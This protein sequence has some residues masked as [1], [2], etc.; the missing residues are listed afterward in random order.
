[1]TLALQTLRVMLVVSALSTAAMLV[2]W[3]VMGDGSAEIAAYTNGFNLIA[4][5]LFAVLLPKRQMWIGALF[6][7]FCFILLVGSKS[8]GFS[9]VTFPAYIMTLLSFAGIAGIVQ[10]ISKERGAP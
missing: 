5:A 6:L 1:M 7:I 9:L 8:G 4:C 3:L 10:W 2:L